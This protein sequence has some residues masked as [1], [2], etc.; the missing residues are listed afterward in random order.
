MFTAYDTHTEAQARR[1]AELLVAAG[2][3]AT[4]R[5]YPVTPWYV[6]IEHEGDLS[7]EAHRIVLEVDPEAVGLTRPVQ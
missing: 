2:F 6:D 3:I 4:V 1:A 7:E 5:S